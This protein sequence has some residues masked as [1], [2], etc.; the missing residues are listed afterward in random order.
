MQILEGAGRPSLCVH[1]TLGAKRCSSM[2]VAGLHAV[3][4]THVH[5]R[6][7]QRPILGLVCD[8]PG[9]RPCTR[10][11]HP[12]NFMNEFFSSRKPIKAELCMQLERVVKKKN[13]AS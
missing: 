1:A 11:L 10:Y 3:R 12:E 6:V 5:G 13:S 9:T 2:C 7:N 8:E 4:P